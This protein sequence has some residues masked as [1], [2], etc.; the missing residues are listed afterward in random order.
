MP[1]R[2]RAG[3]DEQGSRP[4]VNDGEE[5]RLV[6]R[7]RAGDASALEVLIGRYQAQLYRFGMRM[8][9]D[10]EDAKDVLQDTLLA[11]ARGVRRFRGTSSLSTWLYAIAR[12]FCIKKRRRS[13]F[14]PAGVQSLETDVPAEARQLAAPGRHPDEVLAGRQIESALEEAIA[15]L[16][17]PYREVLVLRDM[18]GLTAAEV[19]EVLGIGVPAVKSRLHRARRAVRD[20]VTPLLD[21]PPHTPAAPG[22]C[23][24]VLSLFSRHLEGDISPRVCARMEQHLEVCPR[25]RGACDSLKRTL[26]LC[27]TAAT[28]IEVPEPVQA[29][30]RTALRAFVHQS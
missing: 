11:A 8:C 30:V 5:L 6:E 17:P 24:D 23:P 21:L 15:A 7:A 29:S 1:Y 28:A 27:R 14:A 25:C 4:E 12:S 3:A 22:A 20:V 10:R 26:A 18:E 16:D 2:V 9:G 19:A 13:K